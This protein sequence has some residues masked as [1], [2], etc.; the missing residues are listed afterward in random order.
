[1]FIQYNTTNYVSKDYIDSIEIG[2][3]V[4]FKRNGE[5]TYTEVAD[6]YVEKFLKVIDIEILNDYKRAIKRNL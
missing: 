3:V 4:R 5:Q 6:R 2:L 1:M